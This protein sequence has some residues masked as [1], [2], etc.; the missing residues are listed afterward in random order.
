MSEQENVAIVQQAYDHFKVGNIDGIVALTA[1]DITWHLPAIENV[2]F[3][4]DYN[5]PAGV[6]E[7]FALVMANEEPLRFEPRET[8]AQDDKVVSLGFYHWRVKSTG[9][10][11]SGDFC[12]VFTTRDGKITTFH[13]Y[14]DTAVASKAFSTAASV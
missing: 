2:P 14:T 11:F 4:G 10:E 6:A 3:A 8:I 7:F 13:E 1:D 9:R 5:G 12:H